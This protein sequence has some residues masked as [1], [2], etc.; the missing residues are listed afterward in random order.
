M[1]TRDLVKLALLG[2]LAVQLLGCGTHRWKEDVRLGDGSIITIKRTEKYV[3]GGELATGCWMPCIF[4]KAEIAFE[5][6]DIAITWKSIPYAEVPMLLDISM[7]LPVV[8][9]HTSSGYCRKDI[10]ADGGYTYYVYSI[11]E[12]G[13]WR[14][15]DHPPGPMINTRNLHYYKPDSKADLSIAAKDR[16]LEKNRASYSGLFHRAVVVDGIAAKRCGSWK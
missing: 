11:Y 6:Q 2:L 10:S 1:N 16:W 3:S 13:S 5:Y 15:S 9:S 4:E 8:V 7:G 14:Y 12:N